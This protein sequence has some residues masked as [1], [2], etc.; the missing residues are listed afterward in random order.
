VIGVRTDGELRVQQRPVREGSVRAG[1]D[2]TPAF[3]V[4]V[5]VTA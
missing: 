2:I 5:Y 4:D 3:D 1:A